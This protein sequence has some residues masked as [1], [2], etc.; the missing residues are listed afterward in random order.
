MKLKLVLAAS[1]AVFAAPIALSA[2]AQEANIYVN[3]GYTKFDGD[4]AEPDAI[5]GR[6]GV[7]FGRHFAVEGEASFGLNDDSGVELDNQIGLFGVGK[8]PLN[9]TVTLFGRAGVSRTETSPGGDADGL[10]Y[11][12][13]AEFNITEKDGIRL[14]LT[15]HDYDDGEFDAYGI[16]YVRRF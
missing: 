6:L 8:I 12:V 10:A 9:N 5:T 11:G 13:G 14:D 4:G 3:G 2:S 16:S 7:G 1:A 15:R